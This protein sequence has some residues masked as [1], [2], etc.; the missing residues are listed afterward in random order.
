MLERAVLSGAATATGS[1]GHDRSWHKETTLSCRD[2]G[3]LCTSIESTVRSSGLVAVH[4]VGAE[5]R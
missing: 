5:Q 2:I 1:P 4:L 3:N